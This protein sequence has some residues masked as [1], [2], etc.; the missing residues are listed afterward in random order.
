M[1]NL[2]SVDSYVC[3]LCNFVQFCVSRYILSVVFCLVDYDC[4]PFYL[5]V[6]SLCDS[7]CYLVCV[8]F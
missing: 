7:D 3:A 4:M 1:C 5:C 6:I 8:S 2:L